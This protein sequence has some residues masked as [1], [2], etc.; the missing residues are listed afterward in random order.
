MGNHEKTLQTLETKIDHNHLMEPWLL[1]LPFW[2][3]LSLDPRFLA[4]VKENQRRMDEQRVA[5][6]KMLEESSL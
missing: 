6:E 1:K 5:I 2:E 4:V 3:P